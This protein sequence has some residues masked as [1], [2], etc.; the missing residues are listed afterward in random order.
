M[1]RSRRRKLLRSKNAASARTR[2]NTLWVPVASA[3]LAASPAVHADPAESGELAEVV[4]TAQK[5]SEDL[6]KVPISMQVL[7][8]AKLE[9]LEVK[10]FDDYAKYLPS[11]TFQSLGPGQA[12][13]Y[14]RGIASGADGLH[15]GSAPATGLYLDETPVTTIASSL[16]IH[17]YDIQRVEA[18]A[19]PQGTLYG[20]SSLSGTLRIITNKPDPASFAAGYDVDANTYT[21]GKPGGQFEG[22]VNLPVA[23][24]AAVRLVG[25]Y[26]HDGGY[27]S[28]VPASRTYLL[29]SAPG[30]GV[31]NPPPLTITNTTP[32]HDYAKSDY[33]SIDTF[34]GRAALKIDLDDRWTVTP[35]VLYQH[36]KSNGSFVYDPKIGDLHV[37]DFEPDGTLDQWYQTALTIEGKLSNFDVVYSAGYFGRHTTVQS[38]YSEY[39][40]AY[41]YNGYQ[42]YRN[43]AGQLIDPT[44]EQVQIDAYTKMTHELRVS[45]PATDVVHYT[46][47]VFYQRQTDDIR[48]EYLIAGLGSIPPYNFAVPGQNDEQYLSQQ[49]RADRDYAAFGDVTWN[50]TDQ[51]KLSGGIRGFVA[52]NTLDGFFGFNNLFVDQSN[53]DNFSH[54]S[55]TSQCFTPIIYTSNQPCENTNAGVRESG[56]THRVNLTYQIDP[57]RM[58]YATYSTGFRPGGPNRRAGFPA[59]SPDTLTNYELGWK[60]GFLE[61][62][63]RFNGAIFFEK[64]KDVQLG[65]SGENGITDIVNVGNAQVK[66]AESDLNWLLFDHL[67]LTVSGTYVNALTTTPFCGENATYTAILSTCATPAA[68]SGSRLPVTPELK[69]NAIA[70]YQ[71]DLEDYKLFAQV[72]VVH[73]SSSNSY[74]ETYQEGP[75]GPAPAFTS[76]DL[77]FGVAKGSWTAQFYVDNVSDERGELTRNAQCAAGNGY[78]FTN[79]R[80]YP[81]RPRLIGIKFGEK[82]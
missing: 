63:V 50:I 11:V 31:P 26:E 13:L 56:E 42:R 62:T 48:D 37:T 40:V 47:G 43:N 1:T 44:Q 70:R 25:Y 72:A 36:Q 82:F 53:G 2:P 57:D 69:A 9:E 52:R 17:M 20:A 61:H 16:D 34:G 78:C 6:Q 67:N 10:S 5:R 45:S 12:Q 68:P 4:V 71:F 41:D 76:G 80:V 33:N 28:N 46:A 7:T 8:G 60:T 54:G 19:G 81:I 74:L 29:A 23:D 73:Q 24:N 14:F 39:T 55:G 27:I 77:A 59:Y 79:Y 21:D 30:S 65:V 66:G 58:V 3:L 38:D 35:M 75:T 18:L 32:P 64:W 15:A 22:F 51:W 49:Q